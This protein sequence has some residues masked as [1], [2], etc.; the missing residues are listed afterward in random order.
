MFVFNTFHLIIRCSQHLSN[1]LPRLWWHPATLI[2]RLAN[3]R[4]WPRPSIPAAPHSPH[5]DTIHILPQLLHHLHLESGRPSEW[6][7]MTFFIV[8]SY[9]SKGLIY[10]IN[11]YDEQQRKQ[12]NF[13]FIWNQNF[14]FQPWSIC[15]PAGRVPTQLWIGA[16]W[17][18][19]GCRRKKPS[20]GSKR[21]PAWRPALHPAPWSRARPCPSPETPRPSWTRWTDRSG[22]RGVQASRTKPIHPHHP[23]SFTVRITH[24]RC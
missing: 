11:T 7:N 14:L 16:R 8:Y 20:G 6:R 5:M 12:L 13:F 10:S 18:N 3:S 21:R 15:I 17:Q 22:D 24:S 19:S 9:N 23:P 2:L 1:P 4:L